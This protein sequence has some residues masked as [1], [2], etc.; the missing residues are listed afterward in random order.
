MPWFSE[1]MKDVISCDKLRLL[2]KYDLIRGFPNGATCY[3][4][5]I[6]LFILLIDRA[7]A[8]N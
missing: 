6:T 4:C 5:C 8:G 2:A 3:V 7:N 1:A